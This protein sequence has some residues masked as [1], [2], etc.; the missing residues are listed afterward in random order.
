MSASASLGATV[1]LM[2]FCGKVGAFNVER[3]AV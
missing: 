1:A 2:L 3:G